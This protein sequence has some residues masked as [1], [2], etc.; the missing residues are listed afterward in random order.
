VPAVGMLANSNNFYEKILYYTS[1]IV[2]I[3]TRAALST[4]APSN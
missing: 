2:H 1:H 3:E 4:D